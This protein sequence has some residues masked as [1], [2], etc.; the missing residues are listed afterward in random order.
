MHVGSGP[1]NMLDDVLTGALDSLGSTAC[2]KLLRV[3]PDPE[4][5]YRMM[6]RMTLGGSV[7]VMNA[8]A[9]ARLSYQAPSGPSATRIQKLELQTNVDNILRT[10][11]R[12]NI[13][14]GSSRSCCDRDPYWRI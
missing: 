13:S 9:N 2:M 10:I 4:D 3:A 5:H 1:L 8:A 11:I 14:A 7:C 6:I 12:R